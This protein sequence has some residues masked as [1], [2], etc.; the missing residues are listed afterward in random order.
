MSWIQTVNPATGMVL[1]KY[2]TLSPSEINAKIDLA[3]DAFLA[4]QNTSFKV[5]TSLFLRLAKLLTK[6][7]VSLA[8]LAALEMGKRVSEGLAEIDKCALTCVYFGKHSERFLQDEL[9]QTEAKHSCITFSPLGVVLAIMPWNFPFWQVIRAAAPALMAGNTMLLKHAS[10]VPGCALAI[11]DLFNRAGA[12]RGVFQTLIIS[13][14]DTEKV[15]ENPRVRLVSLTGS[16]EAGSKVASLAG[17]H[18]KKSILELGGSDPYIV[19]QDANLVEAAKTA[20]TARMIVTGQSC[21]AAKRFIVHQ[22]VAQEFTDLLKKHF[23]SKI[24]GD[25]LEDETD[26]GPLSSESIRTTIH[27]QVVRSLALGATLV[28]GGTVPNTNGFYYPPTILT[29]VTEKMPVAS[30]ETFG[31]VAAI[32]KI[33]SNEEAL[34]VANNSRFGLGS[35]LWTNNQKSIKF[36]TS[37]LQ[38]GAVFV[39][40]MVKSDPRLPFGGTKFSGYGRELSSYGLKEFVNIKSVWIS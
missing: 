17:K 11:E 21:I 2:P 4:W 31:P 40:S 25:P 18:L 14:I 8:N 37:Q 5:R 12:P 26:V 24:M 35:S 22:S 9:V 32:I 23:E 7:R 3:Q 28:T 13:A 6:E 16:E 29:N 36:F 39:N 27:D 10:S 33:K 38:A 34:R 30:E 1:K 15:I 19:L 20:A